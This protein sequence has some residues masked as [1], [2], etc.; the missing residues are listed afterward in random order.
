[1]GRKIKIA[2]RSKFGLD[3]K[4]SFLTFDGNGLC[5]HL[6]LLILGGRGLIEACRHL[7]GNLEDDL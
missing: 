1:M 4:K 2:Q 5:G 7:A 3:I 6:E